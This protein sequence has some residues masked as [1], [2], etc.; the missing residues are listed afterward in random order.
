MFRNSKSSDIY[1][2]KSG[3]ISFFNSKITSEDKFFCITRPRRF[4]KSMTANMLVAYYGR[5]CNSHGIFDK[6]SISAD[7]TY[8]KNINKYDVIYIDIARFLNDYGLNYTVAEIISEL[9]ESIKSE[10]KRKY[11]LISYGKTFS[12]YLEKIHRRRHKTFVFVIDEWDAIFRG[13]EDDYAGHKEYLDFLQSFLKNNDYIALVYMTG[14]LP[15]KGYGNESSLNMFQEFTMTNAAPLQKYTGFTED[16]VRELCDKYKRPYSELDFW[17]DGYTVNGVSIYNPKSVVESL[18]RGV[19]DNYWTRTQQFESL[20]SYIG[21]N[22]S[23]VRD[24]IDCLLAGG[25]IKIDSSM[26]KNDMSTITR[27]DEILTLLIHLGYL[28]FDFDTKNVRIP[29]HEVYCEFVT[30]I[31]SM[32]WNDTVRKI[33]RAEKILAA[34]FE[35]DEKTVAEIIAAIHRQKPATKGNNEVI[36]YSVL[37]EAYFTAGNYYSLVPEMPAGGGFADIVFIPNRNTSRPLIVVEL[38][39]NKVDTEK[40]AI[41]QIKDN[42]YAECLSGY[43]G[44]ILLVGISY[45][46]EREEHS[47]SIEEIEKV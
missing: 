34:T 39:S 9:K 44:K 38:K 3:L 13:R 27:R 20:Q 23:G 24:A 46:T 12:I 41:K 15:I 18:S 11:P 1:V 32:G 40:T 21:A 14:I 22:I 8:E 43:K 19:S 30:V 16:E 5:G 29:N 47:C 45:N 37:D 31:G 28:T 36:L 33:E 35:K 4:G 25:T 26:L 2:D 7:P 6:L 17:Y 10:L 42:H